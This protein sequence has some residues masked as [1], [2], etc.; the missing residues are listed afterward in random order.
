MLFEFHILIMK[1]LYKSCFKK[2]N[3]NKERKSD[4]SSNKDSVIYNNND[5]NISG[6][7]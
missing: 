4:N 3:K 2:D 7:G 6:I 1:L 5:N